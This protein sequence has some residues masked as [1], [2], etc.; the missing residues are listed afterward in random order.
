MP[1]AAETAELYRFTVRTQNCLRLV[2]LTDLMTMKMMDRGELFTLLRRQ[3][4]FGMKSW[5]ELEEALNRF[6]SPWFEFA[7]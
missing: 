3:Q 2:G 5:Y 4:N 6:P 1:T 7:L